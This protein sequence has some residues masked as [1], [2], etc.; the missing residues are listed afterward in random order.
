VCAIVMTYWIRPD[1][2]IAELPQA[3]RLAIA[4]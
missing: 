3:G 1:R 2:P 4:G